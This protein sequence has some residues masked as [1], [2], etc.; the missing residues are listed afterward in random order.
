V[1]GKAEDWKPVVTPETHQLILNVSGKD[2]TPETFKE[3]VDELMKMPE[4]SR[5]EFLLI[6]ACWQKSRDR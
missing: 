4:R 3:I 6:Q 2:F 1:S 5:V